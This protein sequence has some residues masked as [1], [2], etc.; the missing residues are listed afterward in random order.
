ME[1]VR[2]FVLDEADSFVAAHSDSMRTIREL[3]TKM[4]KGSVADQ[5][6]QMIVCSATLHNSGVKKLAVS[7]LLSVFRE[8]QSSQFWESPL[9]IR[10]ETLQGLKSELFLD[11]G[12]SEE[13]SFFI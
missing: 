13:H 3:H 4:P 1:H 8:H 9:G 10:E 11:L 5:R 12:N 7:R 2:F 6:L